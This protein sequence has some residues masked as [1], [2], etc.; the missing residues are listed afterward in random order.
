MPSKHHVV[1]IQDLS[2]RYPAAKLVSSTSASTVIPALS[3]IYDS[4]GNPSYQLSDNGAP[5]NLNEMA[6]FA[7]K[8]NIKLQKIP[9]VHPVS[10]PAETFMKPLGKTMKI[11]QNGT[12]ENDALQQLILNY[13]DTPHPA[14]G[15]ATGTMM[16]RDR[17]RTVFPRVSA[18][19]KQVQEARKKD[20]MMK[21]IR[22]DRINTSK[23][24][25]TTR[26]KIGDFVLLR[27]FNKTRKFD[28]V[29]GHDIHKIVVIVTDSV[30]M[31]KREKDGKLFKRHLDDIKMANQFDIQSQPVLNKVTEK[32]EVEE[33]HKI[34]EEIQ[35]EEYSD[36]SDIIFTSGSITDTNEGLRRSGRERCQ[37]TLYF[38]DNFEM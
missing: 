13:R 2:S 9:P 11:A 27:N 37:N 35:H 16:F 32:S 7:D 29:F 25:K 24:R 36:N 18:T 6:K 5:F 28:P 10:N 20:K 33:F 19:E 1:V 8:R 31:A 4:Y 23:F 3:D 34:C 26:I 38:N 22:Q 17:Y 30:V 21:E 14:T 15:L 12:R